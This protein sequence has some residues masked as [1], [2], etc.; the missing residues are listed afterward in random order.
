MQNNTSHRFLV[1]LGYV[2]IFLVST[3]E[4]ETFS[5]C[6]MFLELIIICIALSIYSYNYNEFNFKFSNAV[7][8]AMGVIL[9]M[10]VI[11]KYLLAT[12]S[13]TVKAIPTLGVVSVITIYLISDLYFI[14][15]GH[16]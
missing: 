14:T 12:E 9:V 8:I 2:I 6:F 4:Q 11:Q 10:T 3:Y 5:E 1:L 16:S 15:E 7:L 13:Y